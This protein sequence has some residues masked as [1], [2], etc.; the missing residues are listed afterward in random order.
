MDVKIRFMENYK[1]PNFRNVF[2]RECKFDFQNET[3]RQVHGI[4]STKEKV[5]D[6]KE[7][8]P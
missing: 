5:K 4:F 8:R 3:L 7:M 2:L 6:Y 1:R